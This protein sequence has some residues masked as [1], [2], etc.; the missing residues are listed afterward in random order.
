MKDPFQRPTIRT[1]VFYRDPDTALLWLEK[2]FDFRKSMEVRD[3]AGQ[4]VHAEMRFGDC[5]IVVDAEWAS[6]VTSPAATSGRNTQIVYVQLDGSLDE[7]CRT[8]A[9][10][11]AEILEPPADQYYGDRTYRARDPEGHVWTFSQAFR[12]VGRVEAE[13]LGDVKISGWHRD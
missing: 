3:E 4:L 10:A 1:G 13:R 2:A 6:Y 11:G 7:H 9:A 12:D 8:A 5:S